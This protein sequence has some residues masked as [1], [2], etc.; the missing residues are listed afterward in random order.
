MADCVKT[1][2]ENVLSV[3]LLYVQK[4]SS[5][6][7]TSAITEKKLASALSVRVTARAMPS[8]VKNVHRW[9]RIVMDVHVLLML[10]TIELIYF[11]NYCTRM[12]VKN[13]V[14]LKKDKMGLV[15]ETFAHK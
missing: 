1:V 8:I 5:P 7:A 9:K 15:S 4:L 2:T 11:M 12:N 3:I 13:M 14:F 6:F 10:V